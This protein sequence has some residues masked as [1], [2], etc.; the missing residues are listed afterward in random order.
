MKRPMN[1]HR[2]QDG[3]SL[4][5]GTGSTESIMLTKAK[6]TR[7]PAKT[8][9]PTQIQNIGPLPAKPNPAC[10]T[11]QKFTRFYNGLRVSGWRV[12]A[13]FHSPPFI[14]R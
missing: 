13:T 6:T 4:R 2:P 8:P 14:S 1:L 10:S 5:W 3:G 11:Y 9:A 7:T 12:A